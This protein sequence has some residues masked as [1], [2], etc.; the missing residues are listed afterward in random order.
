[1]YRKKPLI[2]DAEQKKDMEDHHHDHQVTHNYYQVTL[3]YTLKVVVLIGARLHG[4]PLDQ[5]PLVLQQAYGRRQRGGRGSCPLMPYALPPRLP[6][7]GHE[8][9]ICALLT[10]PV[11]C[12]SAKFM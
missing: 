3:N 9:N 12:R 2:S 4:V 8:K 10:L 1:M 6:P 11:H 7:S 5:A